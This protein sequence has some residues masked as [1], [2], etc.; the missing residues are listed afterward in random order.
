MGR[1]YATEL[2]ELDETY[3][4]CVRTPIS[5]LARSVAGCADQPLI[6]VGS[7]GS[8]TSAHFAGFLHTSLTGQASQVFTPYELVTTSQQ[9]T[10]STV[11]VCSAGGSNPDILLATE[12]LIKR[13]PRNLFAVIIKN[14]TALQIQMESAGWPRCHAY[15][16]PTKKDGFLATNSL[17]V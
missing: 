10:R 15:S 2:L 14:R 5:G 1:P 17:L 12:F 6:A 8:L 4:W 13:A 7:G 16:T 9:L 3:K 11:L